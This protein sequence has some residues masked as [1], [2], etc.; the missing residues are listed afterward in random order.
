[1]ETVKKNVYYTS[2]GNGEFRL[3]STNVVIMC[4]EISTHTASHTPSIGRDTTFYKCY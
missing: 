1:M 2:Q 3:L 4:Y